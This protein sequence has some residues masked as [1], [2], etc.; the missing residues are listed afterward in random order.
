[1]Q[2]VITRGTV[3]SIG[4]VVSIN[5]DSVLMKRGQGT[6]SVSFK[7]AEAGLITK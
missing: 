6:F 7:E 1:M 5:H 2:P 4:T 3:L